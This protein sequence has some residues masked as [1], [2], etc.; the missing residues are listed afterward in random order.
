M[1]ILWCLVVV[2]N[3]PIGF[4]GVPDNRTEV[5]LTVGVVVRRK[6]VERLDGL[7]QSQHIGEC[8][9]PWRYHNVLAAPAKLVV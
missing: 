6:A 8:L 4:L 3:F 1:P 5:M 2:V 7:Y 9:Y